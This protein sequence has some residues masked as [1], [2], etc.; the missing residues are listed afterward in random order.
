MSS[1]HSRLHACRP[2]CD[3]ASL[4]MAR[5]LLFSRTDEHCEHAESGSARLPTFAKALLQVGLAR[6]G[7]SSKLLPSAQSRCQAQ[8]PISAQC[9]TQ[10]AGRLCKGIWGAAWNLSDVHLP[11]G[12]CR[13]SE[14]LREVAWVIFDEVHYMQVGSRGACDRHRQRRCQPT[15]CSADLGCVSVAH[16]LLMAT[17][18]AAISGNRRR[19]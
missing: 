13:G 8:H 19:L 3:S 15:S 5:L 14:L 1:A 6:Y 9:C 7:I 17:P 2:A 16:W 11:A 10:Q 4:G 18:S 12:A